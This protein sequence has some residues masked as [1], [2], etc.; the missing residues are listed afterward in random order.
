MDIKIKRVDKS[1]PLPEYKTPGAI[2]FDMYS[3]EEMKIVPKSL[4]LLPSNF[5]IKT[6][7]NYGLILSARSSLAKKKGL[8]LA[9]GVGTIDRDYCG[10][11]DEILLSVYNFTDQEV[12]VEKGER[13]AQGMFM[14][15]DNGNFV[16][17]EQM[18]A[19][20]RGGFGSTGSF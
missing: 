16:E 9:N 3:R 18:E 13:I 5:I 7:E 15:I 8:M 11:N 1:L 19:N 10:E 6:P 2:A 4:A 14:L 12:L 20:D 17:V